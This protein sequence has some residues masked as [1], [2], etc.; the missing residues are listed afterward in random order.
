MLRLFGGGLLV[1][2]LRV[3]RLHALARFPGARRDDQI[4]LEPWLCRALGIDEAELLRAGFIG[5]DDNLDHASALEPAEQ[6]LVSKRRLDL[7]LNHARHRPRPPPPLGP[8]L[9]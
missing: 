7:S 9:D 1:V 8:V 4:A 5:S 3:R 6:P 2:S